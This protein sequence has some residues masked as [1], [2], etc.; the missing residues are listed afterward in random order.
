MMYLLSKSWSLTEEYKD[1]NRFAHKPFAWRLQLAP[2]H[3]KLSCSYALNT[4]KQ[5]VVVNANVEKL[6]NCSA[7]DVVHEA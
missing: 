6:K 3:Y 1:L 5:E 4:E 2:R 7:V